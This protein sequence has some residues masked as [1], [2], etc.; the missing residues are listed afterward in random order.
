MLLSAKAA[1]YVKCVKCPGY[2][3]VCALRQNR[4]NDIIGE[5]MK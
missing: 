2:E 5:N 3:E 4:Q 1:K